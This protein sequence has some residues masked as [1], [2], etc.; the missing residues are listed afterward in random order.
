MDSSDNSTIPFP[1]LD[2]QLCFALYAASNQI[3]RVYRALL[4]EVDLTYPQF[5]VLMS[6][7]EKDGVSIT[8]LATKTGLGKSTMT[9]L[10]KRL[11]EKQ[12]ITRTV[13]DNNERQKCITLTEKGRELSSHGPSITQRAFC[14]THLT[15]EEA[16]GLMSTCF[17][18]IEICELP[19]VK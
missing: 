14:S 11:E 13:V 19:N 10:M 6:L 12:L 1:Q 9:P 16:R 5:M 2:N 8:E 17:K 7:W 15:R 4:T 18:L 3:T